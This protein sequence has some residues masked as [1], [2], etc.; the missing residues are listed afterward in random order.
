MLEARS[1]AIVGASARPGSFGEQM[2]RELH[3]GG[4]D[5]DVYPINPRYDE[6][7]G[8]PCYPSIAAIGRD[9]DLALLGVS[10]A[11]IEDQLRAAAEAHVRAAVIFASCYE[12]PV[13]EAPSLA[14]RL[15]DIARTARM[16]LCG[17]NCMGFLNPERGLRACG[18]PMPEG[19]SAG[20]IAMITHSGSVFSAFAHNDRGMGFNLLVSPGQEFTTTV[21]D[22]LEYALTLESTRVVGLFLETVRDPEGFKRSLMAA[23]KRRVPVVALKVGRTNR[24]KQLVA[25]HSGALAGE[26]GAYE[27][28]FEAYGVLRVTTLDELADTLELL[29]A[30]R[31]AGSGG[32]AAI[33]DSG[34]ERAM[35]IDIA[36]DVGV[37]FA[38][39]SDSTRTRLAAT[40]EPGLPAVNPLDAWGT[41]NDAETI[42]FECMKALVD[43][44]GVAALAFCV[45]LTSEEEGTA[46]YVGVAHDIFAYTNKPVAVLSNLPSAIDP[47]DAASVRGAG[48][49]LLEGTLSGLKAFNHLLAHRDF[50]VRPS[51]PAVPTDRAIRGRWTNRLQRDGVIG[52]IEALEL[53]RDYGVPTVDTAQAETLSDALA[54]AERFGWPVVAK[55]AEAGIRHK[56]DVD[57]VVIGINNPD[58]LRRAYA[59]LCD[60]LGPRVVVEQLAPQ[61]VELSLGVVYD[62]QFGPLV[63]VGAGGVLIEVLRDR[64]FALPPIDEHRAKELIESLAVARLLRGWRNH[65]PGDIDAVA[66]A[67]VAMSTLALDLEGSV[68]AIDVNP[69]IA[70]PEGCVAVDALVVARSGPESQGARV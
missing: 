45:D 46:G 55:T 47:R 59:D 54:A 43:D 25:A 1:V 65:R 39:L 13:H 66:R 51:T 57:G 26:D 70:G 23:A 30:P 35:L 62:G 15:A 10:N 9:V 64:R 8:R 58:E 37:A 50:T 60:R 28:L 44:P 27:A 20:P 11:L 69:L 7:L 53:L 32:L 17:G 68:E 48:V 36:A 12:P 63:M 29:A 21:A 22:Y 41:G 6:V 2:L 56:T 34:G 24:S 52:E 19:L 33:H 18:F 31:R 40:L 5:G 67:L 49:P 4:Y 3:R 16:R 61:G 38:P 14:Q 42:Y